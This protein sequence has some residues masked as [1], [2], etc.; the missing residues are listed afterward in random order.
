[1][2]RSRYWSRI[3]SAA[4]WSCLRTSPACPSSNK[5]A[6]PTAPAHSLQRIFGGSESASPASN[7]D[8]D[9]LPISRKFAT[10]SVMN[11]L[12][13]GTTVYS[14]P[15]KLIFGKSSRMRP[16]KVAF[17]APRDETRTRN[18]AVSR[19]FGSLVTRL[20]SRGAIKATFVGHVITGLSQ[21]DA[22]TLCSWGGR[23]Q[24][25]DHLRNPRV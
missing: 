9:W 18:D 11:Y 21:S 7:A 23:S 3:R 25:Q 20:T 8:S 1:M 12:P 6:R 19:V 5:P 14:Q 2:L 4:R 22:A 13:K 15:C 16:P 10:S 24:R 17:I